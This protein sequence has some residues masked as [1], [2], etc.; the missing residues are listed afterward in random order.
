MDKDYI[1]YISETDSNGIKYYSL[2][3]GIS[4]L[5]ANKSKNPTIF[6]QNIP[7]FF[8]IKPNIEDIDVYKQFIETY[9]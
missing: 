7:S 1:L 4:L 3:N 5:K 9:E 6:N 8:S 2:S